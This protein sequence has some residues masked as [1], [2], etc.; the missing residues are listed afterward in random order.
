MIV[1]IVLPST[2]KDSLRRRVSTSR[3][4]RESL[5]AVF[6]AT[7]FL[8]LRRIVSDPLYPGKLFDE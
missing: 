5:G 2:M 3:P 6:V 7:L 1:T 8:G 4:I